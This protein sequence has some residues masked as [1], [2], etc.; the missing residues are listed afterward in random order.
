MKSTNHNDNLNGFAISQE[1]YQWLCDNL[2]KGK[3]ILELGSGTGTIELTKHW[4]VFSIE[5]NIEWVEI[6][7]ESNYIYAPLKYYDHLDYEWFDIEIINKAIPRKY[8]CLLIDAPTGNGRM[9]ILDFMDLFPIWDIP[10]I[11]DD[12]HREEE[13]RLATKLGA[14][15]NKGVFDYSGLDKCYSI[16]E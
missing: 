15:L 1:L 14:K 16:I 2:P 7:R 13:R 10:I 8:D 9:G 5:Q 4:E 6:A 3:T 12:T 11:I